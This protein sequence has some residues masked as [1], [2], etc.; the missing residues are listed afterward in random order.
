MFILDD[1]ALPRLLRRNLRYYFHSHF[2]L[3]AEQPRHI[4]LQPLALLLSPLSIGHDEQARFT[5]RFLHELVMAHGF[6]V[7]AINEQKMT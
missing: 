7:L 1:R 6:E 2:H 4:R 5:G 3:V